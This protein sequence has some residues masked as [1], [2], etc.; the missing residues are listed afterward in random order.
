MYRGWNYRNTLK[1]LQIVKQTFWEERYCLPWE[2]MLKPVADATAMK[3]TVAKLRVCKVTAYLFLFFI[4]ASFI[5][6]SHYNYLSDHG[7]SPWIVTFSGMGCCREIPT[8]LMLIQM[9]PIHTLQT[10]F[11]KIHFDIIIPSALR[12]SEWPLSWLDHPDDMLWR[13]YREKLYNVLWG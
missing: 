9:N 6:H 5:D 4:T 3:V 11:L 13:S 12:S 8:A 10:C 2:R 7:V 1:F